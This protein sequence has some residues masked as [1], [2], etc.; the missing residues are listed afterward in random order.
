M[1]K[2]LA[3]IVAGLVL[4][5]LLTLPGRAADRQVVQGHVPAAVAKLNLQPLGRL[6]ADQQMRISINLPLRNTEEM[7]QLCR[8][9]YNPASPIT[10]II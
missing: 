2:K 5:G 3:A 6:Q 10:N 8:Q 1:T 4:L 7:V 9:I